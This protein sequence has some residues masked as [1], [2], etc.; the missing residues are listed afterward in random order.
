M[1]KFDINKVGEALFRTLCWQQALEIYNLQS[2]HDSSLILV[3]L[4]GTKFRL[5]LL[6]EVIPLFIF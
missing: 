1:L 3:D 2:L 4:F 5:H 6:T